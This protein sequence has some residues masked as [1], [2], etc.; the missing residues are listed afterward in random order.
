MFIA[1]LTWLYNLLKSKD[2]IF[3]EPPQKIIYCYSVWT[4]LFGDMEK[5]L[6][7]EF[8]QGMPHPVKIKGIFDG[9]HHLIC[10]DDLWH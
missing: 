8:V 6:D 9:H 10:L 3:E 5:N 4:K 1:T 7:T 2:T